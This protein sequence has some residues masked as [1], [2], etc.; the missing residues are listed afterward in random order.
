MKDRKMLISKI[1]QASMNY[2]LMKAK[3]ES[4]LTDLF[5]CADILCLQKMK[6]SQKIRNELEIRK[7]QVNDTVIQERFIDE[8]LK[9]FWPNSNL[10]GY[11]QK[12]KK[13]KC[14]QERKRFK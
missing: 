11:Y 7:N 14:R 1:L 4:N 5:K 12:K 2:L 9:L 8:R 10:K 3:E 13:K 6:F